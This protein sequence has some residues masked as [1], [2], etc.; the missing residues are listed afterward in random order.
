MFKYVKV[1]S[2]AKVILL[3]KKKSQK[4]L[5]NNSVLRQGSHV[6]RVW[7]CWFFFDHNVNNF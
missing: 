3:K 7:G 2:K 6:T 4:F 1:I 5:K